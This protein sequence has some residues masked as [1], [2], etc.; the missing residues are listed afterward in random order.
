MPIPSC[1]CT[2]DTNLS[3]FSH[4]YCDLKRQVLGVFVVKESSFYDCGGFLFV[5]FHYL[6]L[7]SIKEITSFI[8]FKSHRKKICIA[9][10]NE[11]KWEKGHISMV[12]F[13]FAFL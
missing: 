12:L 8:K 7:W 11:F 4:G 13:I 9:L 2:F 3:A 5:C 10:V 1:A 6:T